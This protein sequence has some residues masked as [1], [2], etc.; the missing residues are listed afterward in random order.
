M[1][2]ISQLST[3]LWTDETFGLNEP[4]LQH[5]WLRLTSGG[6]AIA[7]VGAL[8]EFNVWT[9]R[10]DLGLRS[11]YQSKTVDCTFG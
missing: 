9:G 8:L 4:D 5:R 2:S 11:L 6:T 10:P 3:A 7:A 1:A